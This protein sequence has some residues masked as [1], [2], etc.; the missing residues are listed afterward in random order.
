MKCSITNRRVSK[1]SIHITS[2]MVLFI[3]LS[4]TIYSQVA[5]PPRASFIDPVFCLRVPLICLLSLTCSSRGSCLPTCV[6]VSLS[7][8][9]V[10]VMAARAVTSPI[11]QVPQ[12]PGFTHLHI[13]PGSTTS[14][15]QQA[16][17]PGQSYLNIVV[18]IIKLLFTKLFHSIWFTHHYL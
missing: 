11:E 5:S 12:S 18:Q 4:F 10:P 8:L 9:L 13:M 16:G 6:P 15:P 7:C 14:P 2:M 17:V 3:F 1:M